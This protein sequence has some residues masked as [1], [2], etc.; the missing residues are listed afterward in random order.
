[1]MEVNIELKHF[2]TENLLADVLHIVFVSMLEQM[3]L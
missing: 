1:M 2:K 3:Q